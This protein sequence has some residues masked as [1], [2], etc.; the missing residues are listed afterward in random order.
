MMHHHNMYSFTHQP[1]CVKERK[2]VERIDGHWSEKLGFAS[3]FLGGHLWRV[4]SGARLPDHIVFTGP[5]F[6]QTDLSFVPEPEDGEK[7]VPEVRGEKKRA[8][9]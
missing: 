2:K 6:K 5:P 4:M 1:R 8:D 7:Q 9:A 3:F